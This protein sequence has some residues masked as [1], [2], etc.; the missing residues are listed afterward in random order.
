MQHSQLCAPDSPARLHVYVN[1][2]KVES[3]CMQKPLISFL[4]KGKPLACGAPRGHGQEKA[5]KTPVLTAR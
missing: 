4:S 2:S 1:Q 5:R 3:Y